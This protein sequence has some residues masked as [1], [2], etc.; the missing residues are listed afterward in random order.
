MLFK[1]TLVSWDRNFAFVLFNSTVTLPLFQTYANM[2]SKTMTGNDEKIDL[3][4]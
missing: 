3:Q 4:I 2:D 1:L